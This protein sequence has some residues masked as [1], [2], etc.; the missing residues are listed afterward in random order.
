MRIVQNGK[1][2]CERFLYTGSSFLIQLTVR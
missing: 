1:L 2:S